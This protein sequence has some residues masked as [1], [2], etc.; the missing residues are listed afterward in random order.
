MDTSNSPAAPR[1]PW[2]KGRITG[3]KRPLKLKEI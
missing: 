1:I 3:Q 2:N